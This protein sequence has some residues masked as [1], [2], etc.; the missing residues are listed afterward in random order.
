MESIMGIIQRIL[1]CI[2][3]FSAFLPFVQAAPRDESVASVTVYKEALASEVVYHY[4][5]TNKGQYPI[6]AF[7]VGFD[8]YHGVPEL[9]G[10]NP[11]G[12]YAPASWSSRVIDMEESDNFE[13]RWET[14]S[15]PLQPGQSLSGFKVSRTGHDQRFIN[16]H[17]TVI[18]DGPPVHASS[19]LQVDDTPP[20]DT[21]PPQISVVLSPNVIW[22]PNNK[23]INVTAEISISDE[24]DPNPA[25]KLVSV[26]CNECSDINLDVFDAVV[27]TDDR[28]FQV[29]A[30]RT[31]KRKEGRVYTFTY[32]AE[33][34]SG[35]IAN[36]T[37]TVSI[38]HDK[39]K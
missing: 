4:T 23:L 3:V 10:L 20:T 15:S 31:G 13:I 1:M 17:W 2:V 14:S 35:N 12:I 29:K 5:L 7:S 9:S 39:R 26:E 37:A 27:Q 24:R 8:Y 6:T 21:V 34:S 36:A 16:S 30:S 25:V 32:Q 22:P 19:I 38:P 28:E 33:D 18:I 11:Q